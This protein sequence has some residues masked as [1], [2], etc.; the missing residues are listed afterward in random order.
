MH[1]ARL[2]RNLAAEISKEQALA[3]KLAI[4]KRKEEELAKKLDK[5]A[6]A[7][8]QDESQLAEDKLQLA[9]KVRVPC[10]IWYIKNQQADKL[11]A[12]F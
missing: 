7:L 11:K 10:F 2:D 9:S 5:T 3:K 8:E 1:I 6:Q 12:C 4:E